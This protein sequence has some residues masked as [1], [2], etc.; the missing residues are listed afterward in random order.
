MMTSA[1]DQDVF[2][3]HFDQARNRLPG[4][5]IDWISDLRNTGLSLFK[6]VG[7]P[8]AK[9]ELWKFTS[10]N[11]LRKQQFLAPVSRTEE[12]LSV[13]DL[14]RLLG[15]QKSHRLVF[16]DGFYS[17]HL[18]D[19]DLP[20]G[21][22]L[23]SFS[24]ALQSDSNE[25]NNLQQK[26]QPRDLAQE[27]PL[28]ALNTALMTDGFIIEIA[29]DIS[30]EKIIE[31]LHYGSGTPQSSYHNR[32]MIMV[33]AGSKATIIE[34]VAD[35][36]AHVYFSNSVT[37]V[38]L[39]ENATL[40]HYR[41]QESTPSA[42]HVS[43]VQADVGNGSSYDS[44]ILNTGGRM[45]RSDINVN[46]IAPNS[47]CHINGA[48]MVKDDQHC[49]ITTRVDHKTPHT[50]CDE[51]IKG[52]LAGKSRGVFQGKIIVH[53]QAQKTVGNQSHRAMLLSDTAEVDVKPELEIFADDV[54]CSHGCTSGQI[55]EDALF[56][57][58]SRGLSREQAQSL[59]VN[60]F[61]AD[62]VEALQN[63]DLKDLFLTRIAD[64]LGKNPQ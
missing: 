32:N 53:E 58:R 62:A 27:Q 11:P 19:T 55:D 16:V 44:F 42:F 6:E 56:Y 51:V 57:L 35:R 15:E 25:V 24:A 63:E 5:D 23:Q 38:T 22:K 10:L 18:S 34:Q 7:L 41:I 50:S 28:V 1:N 26:L 2:I 13:K 43:S 47:S 40:H 30:V 54:I 8:S 49:D 52:I 33:G 59:L 29:K 39:A 36:E 64:W 14:P 21:V 20:K 4:A 60:A 12:K 31:I 48:Y 9:T 61:L 45:A 17:E 3:A 46:L 37:D